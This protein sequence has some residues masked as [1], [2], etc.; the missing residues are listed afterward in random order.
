MLTT[1]ASAKFLFI[2]V[3]LAVLF[4]NSA[5]FNGFDIHLTPY[6]LK[7]CSRLILHSGLLVRVS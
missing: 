7:V 6:S 4:A 2:D 5:C 3:L 1:P